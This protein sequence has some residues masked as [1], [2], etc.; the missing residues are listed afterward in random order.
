MVKL[1]IDGIPFD[2]G[3]VDQWSDSSEL[4]ETTALRARLEAL[5]RPPEGGE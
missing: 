3:G 2:I 4:L 5:Y 1:K